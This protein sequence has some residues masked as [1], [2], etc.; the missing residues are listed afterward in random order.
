V[1]VQVAGEERSG[2]RGPSE[3]RAAVLTVDFIGF[4][5]LHG[6]PVIA[7]A[8]RRLVPASLSGDHPSVGHNSKDV[9]SNRAK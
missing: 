6:A 2:R 5:R 1:S 3:T 4:W 8:W 7:S 9:F